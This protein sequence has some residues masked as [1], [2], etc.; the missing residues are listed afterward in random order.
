MSSVCSYFLAQFMSSSS[1]VSS[2]KIP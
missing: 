1:S 2:R